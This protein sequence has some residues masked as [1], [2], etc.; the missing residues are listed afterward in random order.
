MSLKELQSI[1]NIPNLG[2]DDLMKCALGAKTNE[3]YG[4]CILLNEGPLSIQDAANLLGKSRSTVQRLLQGLVEKRLAT[5][6]EELI[7]LGG[8]KFVYKAV[9]AEQLKNSIIDMLN[10][11]YN[12]MLRELENLPE[13]IQEVNCSALF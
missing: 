10:M 1:L 3:I 5:R 7:G 12:K 2:V 6:E 4:Y 13:K 11:W 9:P 8:Y